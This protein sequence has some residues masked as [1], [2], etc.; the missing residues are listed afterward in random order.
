M[1]EY[2]SYAMQVLTHKMWVGYY[3]FRAG[4]YWRG[5]THDLSKFSRA[6]FGPY[7]RYFKGPKTSN[8][9][10]EEFHRAWVH[11]KNSNTH[12]YE[13][14]IDEEGT[15]LIMPY[16]AALEL[17]CDYLGACRAYNTGT[18][19]YHKELKFWLKKREKINIHPRIRAFVD[20]MMEAMAEAE[21]CE[22]LT[23][24]RAVYMARVEADE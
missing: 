17:V 21:S 14:W 7:A 10:E 5:I 8:T 9:N 1:L 22:P 12:H 13:Y 16:E 11:H 3:C 6:E 2:A 23:N 4:I 20:D 19:S 18:F 15:P 24:A